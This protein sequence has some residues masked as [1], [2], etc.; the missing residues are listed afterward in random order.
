VRGQGRSTFAAPSPQPSPQ[1]RKGAHRD[2]CAFVDTH[3]ESVRHASWP[4]A[5]S[6]ASSPMANG[7]A[8]AC[9]IFASSAAI[10]ASSTGSILESWAGRSNFARAAT[11][12][13]PP[14]HGG[15]SD[16]RGTNDGGA[17]QH[18]QSSRLLIGALFRSEPVIASGC[19]PPAA[20]SAAPFVPASSPRTILSINPSTITS[21]HLRYVVRVRRSNRTKQSRNDS[22]ALRHHRKHSIVGRRSGC[23]VPSAN[24]TP[25][26]RCQGCGDAPPQ[27]RIDECRGP[28]H[29]WASLTLQSQS[30]SRAGR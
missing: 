22:L 25:A 16:S 11:T 29:R 8:R 28:A 3:R 2:R 20:V 19:E 5:S 30:A 17:L 18:L 23:R 21:R 1:T 13:Q 14:Q 12:A 9:A 6:I 24:R 4:S 7:R 26:S 27:A 10:A 15:D